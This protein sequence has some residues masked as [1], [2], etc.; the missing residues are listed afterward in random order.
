MNLFSVKIVL[1]STYKKANVLLLTLLDH[2]AKKGVI[3]IPEPKLKK[4]KKVIPQG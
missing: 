1:T 3:N 4:K 2:E